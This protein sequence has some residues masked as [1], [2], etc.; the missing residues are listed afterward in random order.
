MWNSVRA[1]IEELLA[2]YRI[3][4]AAIGVWQ[5]GQI[6]DLAAGV[7]NAVTREPARPDTVYQ[8][9][10]MTKTWTALAFMQL[11]DEGK[12]DLDEP[13]RTHLPA[14]RVADPEVSEGLTPRHLLNHT[15]GIEEAYGDPGEDDDV[16]E[17]M[18]ANIAGAP[19]VFPLGHTH[20]Y[21]AALG[22]AILA[23]VMEVIDGERWDAVMR[24][25]L[26]APLGLTGTSTGPADPDRA[27][28]GHLVGPDGPV[29]SP[30]PRLPRAFGPGGGISSTA[31][32]VL[33]MAHVL[34]DGGRAPDGTRVLSE[35]AI[36]TMLES[37]VPVPDAYGFGPEWALGLM[38]SDWHGRTVYGHD[39]STVGHSARLRMI[40]DAGLALVLLTNAGPREAF[41]REVCD[42]ILPELGGPAIPE[43]PRP[44]T[45]SPSRY[46]G[47]YERPGTR[48]TLSAEDGRPRLTYTVHPALTAE[49][50]QRICELL[51]VDDTQFLVIDPVEDPWTIALFDVRDGVPQYLHADCRVFPRAPDKGAGVHVVAVS[52]VSDADRFWDALKSA[53]GQLPRGAAWTVAVAGTDGTKAVNVI[54][55]DSVDGVRSFVERHVG[56]YATTEY[57]EADAANAVGLPAV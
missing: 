11:V 31:R 39:G 37:R 27:S 26:F 6:T 14:F 32:D 5:D 57:F 9:G 19:Q 54:V 28:T 53:Y 22:Y 40:P 51:P 45:E 13:V 33:T 42:A 29:I 55:H 17:R 2:D 35:Q 52:T 16:Y 44:T 49:P 41:F 25:R 43:L 21:S 47:V 50:E 20:G 38:V 1:R 30:V 24:R 10:S 23:R 34:L 56:P 7:R 18:V 4:S 36:T 46:E 8:C 48:Y 3:P 15:N 12:A